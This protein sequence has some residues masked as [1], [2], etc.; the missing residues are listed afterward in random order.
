MEYV[1]DTEGL[2]RTFKE[3]IVVGYSNSSCDIKAIA[4]LVK[5]NKGYVNLVTGTLWDDLKNSGGMRVVW[6]V[7]PGDRCRFSDDKKKWQLKSFGGFSGTY[8]YPF[9][10]KNDMHKYIQPDDSSQKLKALDRL[11]KA[12]EELKSAR[13]LIEELD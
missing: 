1:L 9:V 6:V 5:T 13:K 11:K 10:G 12:E 7:Y 8:T 4:L 2:K 3:A